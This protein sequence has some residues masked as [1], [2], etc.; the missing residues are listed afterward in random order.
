MSGFTKK[1]AEW[2]AEELQADLMSQDNVTDYNIL[3][4]YD[5]II[6]GGFLCAA[7][8][9]GVTLIKNNFSKLKNKKIIIFATGASPSKPEL[10]P[11]VLNKNFTPEEQKIIKFYYF[12]G[13]F[14]YNKLNW[15]NKLLMNIMKMKIK[16][17]KNPTPD[18]KG[19][20]AAFETPVDYTEKEKINDL[21]EYARGE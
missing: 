14:D 8:I 20:L 4:K 10:I 12:R 7:G 13:G 3:L 17:T 2:I 16:A 15:V 11:E 5:N 18:E 6:F 9:S 1:Y 21:L 19:M